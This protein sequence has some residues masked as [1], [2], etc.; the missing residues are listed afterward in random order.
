MRRLAAAN[1]PPAL[2]VR[3]GYTFPV[4]LTLGLDAKL[5]IGAALWFFVARDAFDKLYPAGGACARAPARGQAARV[6]QAL[7][8]ANN[9][10]DSAANEPGYAR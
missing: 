7:A 8:T 1:A 3:C 6:A 4:F 9:W 2:S 5:I 10:N